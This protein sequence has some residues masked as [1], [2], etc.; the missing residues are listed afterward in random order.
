[1]SLI[2]IILLALI[3]AAV[4]FSLWKTYRMLSGKDSCCGH[5]CDNCTICGSDK[6]MPKE[7]EQETENKNQ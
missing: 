6:T 3:G 1:M 5:N 4:L 2:E 7:K